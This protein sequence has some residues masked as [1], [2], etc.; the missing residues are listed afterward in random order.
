MSQLRFI[1]STLYTL[2]RRYPGVIDI[3]RRTHNTVDVATGVK[4]VE[5][6]GVHVD[7]AI[8]LPADLSR[9]A[10]FDRTYVANDRDFV[11]GTNFDVTVRTFIVDRLD[12]PRTFEPRMGDYIVH[13]GV[14]YNIQKIKKF[15]DDVGFIFLG[16]EALNEAP[17]L[18]IA[19]NTYSDLGL[20]TDSVTFDTN[21]SPLEV[22]IE[23]III[24]TDVAATGVPATAGDLLNL[25][26]AV[27]VEVSGTEN[28]FFIAINA[29]TNP[30]VIGLPVYSS[31]NDLV[32]PGVASDTTKVDILGFVSDIAPVAPG[33]GAN[34]QTNGV[35]TATTSQWDVVTGGAGG[36]IPEMVYY[37]DTAVQGRI[38]LAPPITHGDFLV[39]LGVAISPTEFDIEIQP[40]IGL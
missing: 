33:H 16:K 8:V 38:T 36:L 2:K 32:Q 31:G 20:L 35:L 19:V 22:H 27:Q 40:P 14:R 4:T 29:W 24:L 18:S 3:I 28:D 15:E 30:L 10:L 37:L 21:F 12:L 13:Q 1:R 25:F 7:R 17:A 5:L 9:A 23:D 11:Y 6:S 26:Q 39:R 34:I